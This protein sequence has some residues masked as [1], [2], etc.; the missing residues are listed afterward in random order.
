MERRGWIPQGNVKMDLLASEDQNIDWKKLDECYKYSHKCGMTISVDEE[1]IKNIEE[2]N[3]Y[4]WYN[5]VA[6]EYFNSRLY[7][8][9]RGQRT[10]QDDGEYITAECKT[11]SLLD[12]QIERLTV[13]DDYILLK[14]GKRHSFMLNKYYTALF[15]KPVFYEA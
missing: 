2:E 1:E 7:S 8:F 11:D 15:Y 14:R 9:C 5:E 13:K 3:F 12:M 10:I 6:K 4:N